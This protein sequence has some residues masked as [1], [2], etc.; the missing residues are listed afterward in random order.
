MTQN[1]KSSVEIDGE[2]FFLC[3]TLIN[4]KIQM[5]RQYEGVNPEWRGDTNMSHRWPAGGFIQGIEL[6]GP[7]YQPE[8][9]RSRK[10]FGSFFP[11]WQE[12][13]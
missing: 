4:K 3:S 13:E 8:R 5:A 10:L 6:K 1:T 11:L 7:G 12:T 2:I 9:R